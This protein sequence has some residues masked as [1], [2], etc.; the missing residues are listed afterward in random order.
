[1]TQL[2]KFFSF[3]LITALVSC[4]ASKKANKSFEAGEYSDAIYQYEKSLKPGDPESNFQLAEAYRKSNRIQEAEPYYLAAVDAGIDNESA[5]YYYAVALKANDDLKRAN[6]VLEDYLKKGQD[7]A[8]MALAERELNNLDKLP[9]I[10]TRVNYFR[11]K[12]LEA[13]NTEFAE[14]SPF[15]HAGKL[16]FTSNRHGGKIYKGTGTPFT[17]IYVVNTRGA[18]VDLATL[19][20]LSPVVNEPNVNLGSITIS[21]DGNT[22]IFAKGNSGKST[23]ASEVNLY[24]TRYRNGNWQTPR[25]LSVN[26]QDTWDST[27]AISPDGKTLYFSSN[28]E[29]GFGGLD[30]YTASLNRR[31]RWVDVRN[32]GENI[33]T[34]GNE[35]FPYAGGTGKL[36]FSSDGWPGFG[37]LDIFEATRAG[38][39][40]KLENLG[41]PINSNADDFG[42]YLFNPSRGFFTSN[43]KGGK[44]D[45]DIYTFVN[46]DPELRIVNY[47]LSGTT[48]T[49]DE[50]NEL[51]PL[52]NTK[53]VLRDMKDNIIDEK[54][55]QVDGKYRFRVYSEEEYNLVAEKEEYF[56]T[57]IDFSTIGKSADKASLEKMITNV[58]FEVDL[59]LDQIVVDKPIVLNNIYYDLNKA[60]IKPEAAEE[61]DK[62]VTLMQDNPSINIE[63]SSHTDVRSSHDYNM[64]LSQRRAQSAVNYIAS[65]GIEGR[66]MIAKGYGET[67][68]I[69]Q[70]ATTEKQHQVNR[71][72]EFKVTK[73]NKKFAQKHAEDYDESDRFFDDVEDSQ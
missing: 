33:N 73:Y 57:R 42:L 21:G 71:R 18:N 4:S 3:F 55:T 13:I 14:Y 34:P 6:K 10:E 36:Y 39:Q 47:W 12:N 29:G 72:T 40:V 49:R 28:R 59:P 9:E 37:G 66:R 7:D 27:P 11:V 44:G 56:T 65:Q 63:L 15:Y 45:D 53:V 8:I 22:I 30:I 31:G 26:G 61:L 68:L 58:E 67:K 41:A 35:I 5:Y 60:D 70:N 62:L 64:N 46:D 38:G 32:M 24:F 25:P 20:E 43:R 54:F 19:E 52:S 1:M 50:N 51:V 2:S 23:G 48:L 16:Y 69:I 17:D